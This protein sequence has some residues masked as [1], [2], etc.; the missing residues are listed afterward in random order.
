MIIRK[1][2]LKE[3]QKL[4]FIEAECFPVAEAADYVTLKE[5]FRSFHENFL[6][7]EINGQIV[8][9][10]NGNTGNSRILPDVY[11]H[12]ASMHDPDG[13]YMAVFGLDVE[14][15]YQHQ[16]IAHSLLAAYIDLAKK[17]HKKG[18]I[19][20]C[21]DHLISFYQESG[22]VCLGRSASKHGGAVWNDMIVEF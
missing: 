18:V 6:A 2:T 22:F 5:R 21:K 16:G 20:T 11:Y 1:P 15:D 8:G 13:D 12:D 7:A 19:L 17:R 4:A 3:V 14:P 10:I 9:F